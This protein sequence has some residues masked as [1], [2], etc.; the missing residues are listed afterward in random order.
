MLDPSNQ[1]HDK[2][3]CVIFLFFNIELSTRVK[4]C[5]ICE[6]SIVSARRYVI[7]GW[8]TMANRYPPQFSHVAYYKLLLHRKIWKCNF[9]GCVEIILKRVRK[10]IFQY[11]I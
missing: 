4:L 2:L 1:W 5:A 7:F 3:F 9:H 6:Q 10:S 8:C 11:M